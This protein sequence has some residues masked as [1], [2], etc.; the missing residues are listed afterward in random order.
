MRQELIPIRRKLRE[1]ETL[2]R[3]LADQ[4]EDLPEESSNRGRRH[5]I[6][7]EPLRDAKWAAEFLGV[8]VQRVYHLARTGSLPAIRLGQHYRFTEQTLIDWLEAGGDSV[9]GHSIL[10]E[11]G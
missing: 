1:L 7:K 6:T 8:G 9:K 11:V 4:L 10:R 2:A 3:E 5:H